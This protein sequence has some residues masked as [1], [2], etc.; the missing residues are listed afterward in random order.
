MMVFVLLAAVGA[1]VL[2]GGEGGIGAVFGATGGYILSWPLAAFAI[3]FLVEKWAKAG[4]LNVWTLGFTHII[5]GILFI[6]CIGFPWLVTVLSLP[7]NT[8]T[9]ITTLLIFIPG[10]LVKAFLA[11]TVAFA[12]YRAIPELKPK[13]KN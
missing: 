3:G 4:W 8:E 9:F 13:S 10:D 1:P 6:H 5:G 11:T 12:L 2:S 7:L